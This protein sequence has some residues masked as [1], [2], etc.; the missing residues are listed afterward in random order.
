MKEFFTVVTRKGQ[1]TVPAEIRQALGLKEGDKVALSLAESGK[2]H[3]TLR[4]ARSVAAMTFGA[5]AP[6]K[7]PED[8]QELRRIFEEGVAEEVLAEG[9]SASPSQHE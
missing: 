4:P 8:F 1:I 2:L 7:R 6:R 5:V 9:R 3:A